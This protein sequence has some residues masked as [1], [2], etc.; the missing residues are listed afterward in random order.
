MLARATL[1]RAAW[2]FNAQGRHAPLPPLIFLTDDERTPDPFAAIAALPAGS[3]VIVRARDAKRR[4]EIGRIAA[5]IAHAHALM[6][7]VANDAGLAAELA[8]DGLH[9]S[10]SEIETAA[11]HRRQ[12]RLLTCAAHSANAVLRAHRAGAHAVLLS[13][14][15]ATKSHEGRASLGIARLRTI[16]RASPIP[17]YALGGIDAANVARLNGIPLA[18]LAAIGALMA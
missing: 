1:A 5:R 9:F 2:R 12:S 8:A 15:F 10:E 3:L 13:P 4:R 7:S 14:I 18:G 17:V 16:A 6:L 11:R